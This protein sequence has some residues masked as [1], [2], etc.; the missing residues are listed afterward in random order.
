MSATPT[1]S[2]PTRRPT[3]VARRNLPTGRKLQR[4]R[5]RAGL[6]PEQLALDL[7]ISN[8]TIRRIEDVGMVPT[9]RVALV[10][11]DWAGEDV[12]KLWPNL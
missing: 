3:R 8:R 6:S 4:I 10:M 7:G 5:I 11:A 9:V 2:Q 12:F 1:I